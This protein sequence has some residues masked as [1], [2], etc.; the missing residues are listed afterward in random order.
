MH[1]HAHLSS[2]AA[3]AYYA[4]MTLDTAKGVAKGNRRLLFYMAV[5][6]AHLFLLCVV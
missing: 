4:K 1:G 6:K 3:Y 5:E 2:S